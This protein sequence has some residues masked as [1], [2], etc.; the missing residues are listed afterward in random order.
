MPGAGKLPAPFVS[1]KGGRGA[2]FYYSYPSRA[3]GKDI[4]IIVS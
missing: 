4:V 1:A 3:H 2:Y